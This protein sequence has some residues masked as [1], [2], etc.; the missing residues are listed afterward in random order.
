MAVQEVR[1][2]AMDQSTYNTFDYGS[3]SENIST[4][5]SD[6]KS[7]NINTFQ[8]EL[9]DTVVYFVR[10]LGG[11]D[12][13]K[14]YFTDFGGSGTGVYTFVQENLGSNDISTI[15]E[16]FT[17]IYPNPAR[18][19]IN[20]IYDIDGACSLNIYDLNGRL[21]YSENIEHN[22]DLNKHQINIEHLPAGLYNLTVT[23][24]VKRGSVKFI[25][26]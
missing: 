15:N 1:E 4:I 11:G 17:E 18:D 20:L 12:V 19:Q 16:A 21:V 2:T 5:G 23:D 7:F 26:K 24:N 10:A 3:F 8:W 13:Y 6:W 9:I 25:K 14:I 22:E